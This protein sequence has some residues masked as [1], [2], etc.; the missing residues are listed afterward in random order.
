MRV[1]FIAHSSLG[2]RRP[3]SREMRRSGRSRMGLQLPK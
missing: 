2:D 1:T 3:I